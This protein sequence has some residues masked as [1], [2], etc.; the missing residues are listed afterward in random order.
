[1]TVLPYIMA[2]RRLGSAAGGALTVPAQFGTGDWSVADAGTGGDITITVTTLPDDGGS[3]L[4]DLEYQIDG[5][6]WVSLGDTATGDYPVSGLTDDVEVDVAIRA[7]NAVGAGTASATKAVTP[8]AAGTDPNFANVVLLIAFDG[9]HG[10]TS[11]TDDSNSGHSLTFNGGAQISTTQSKFGGA[12]LSISGVSNSFVSTPDSADWLLSS[13]NS[14][15]FTVE[16]WVR[17]TTTARSIQHIIGQ[18][19]TVTNQR[20]WALV[21]TGNDLQFLFSTTGTDFIT[22]TGISVI[23]INTWQHVVVDKDA[24]GKIRVYVGGTMVASSTPAN[25][26]FHDSTYELRIGMDNNAGRELYGWADESRVTKGVARY[27]SDSGYT[28]PTEAFPRS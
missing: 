15:E 16:C 8:T 5:G 9:I 21:I 6:S 22:T 24:T 23:N 28:V 25:S 3:A 13:A 18:W 4:T 7:V 27:A 20:A 12:S 10:A 11:A 14:D 2:R 1:M 17:V 19:N 26:A